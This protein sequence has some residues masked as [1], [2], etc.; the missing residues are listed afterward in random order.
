MTLVENPAWKLTLET[1][2]V[3]FL[4]KPLLGISLRKLILRTICAN[5]RTIWEPFLETLF[6]NSLRALFD[7]T[8]DVM[9]DSTV[10]SI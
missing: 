9:F 6:E 7:A 4:W 8:F 10:E 2:F 1:L 3:N 5:V